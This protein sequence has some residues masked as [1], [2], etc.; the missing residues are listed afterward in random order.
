MNWPRVK[1]ESLALDEP[2]SFVDGPF[3]SNLKV[4]EYVDSGVPLIRIQNV[5]PFKYV[6]KE[7]KYITSEKA[8]ELKRHDY[9]GGDLVI[10]KL[11]DPCGVACIIRECRINCVNGLSSKTL[12]KR[13]IYDT[14]K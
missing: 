11:G 8:M 13:K 9:R 10:T 6:P 12:N 5:K 3:G 1:L 2:N 14:Q 4:S 7:I